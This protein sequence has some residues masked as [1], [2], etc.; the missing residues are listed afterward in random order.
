MKFI[1]HFVLLLFIYGNGFSQ[2]VVVSAAKV[3]VLY[4]GAD[5]PFEY[6]VNNM[7]CKNYQLSSNN[8]AIKCN[9]SCHCSINPINV[10][11]TVI[12]IKDKKGKL[13][14]SSIY[15][16]K[17]LPDPTFHF[18]YE[19]RYGSGYRWKQSYGVFL[20]TLSDFDFDVQFII[21]Q[22]DILKIKADSIGIIEKK[23]TN[24]GAYY[25]EE[26]KELIKSAKLND[27]FYYEN[28]IVVEPNGKE[29]KIAGTAFK[30]Y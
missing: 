1:I 3:N 21:K 19:E 23:I 14:D 7:N 10:G 26:A 12:Y 27:V 8:G 30:Y 13:I 29:R 18:A 16:T 20:T 5:N 28:I 22:F 25:S 2:N 24:I 15:R 11:T 4:A 6:A 17:S 9:D